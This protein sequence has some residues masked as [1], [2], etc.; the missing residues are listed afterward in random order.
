MCVGTAIE[1]REQRDAFTLVEL[2]V[3]IAVIAILASLLLPA[4]GRAKVQAR[5]VACLNNLKQLGLGT[6]MYA[7]DHEGHYTAPTWFPPE[8]PN[9]PPDADRSASDDDLSFLYA[10][11]PNTKSFN[12]PAASRHTIRNDYWVNMT[13]TEKVLGDLV[14]LAKQ[15]NSF[16]GLSYEVFGL[17][18][19]TS[20]PV[21]R[22]KKT[23]AR[24]QSFTIQNNPTFAGMRPGSSDVFLMVDS[25]TGNG[26]GLVPSRG[27]NSN[28]PD[29]EDNHGNEGSNM[30]FCDGHAEFV[31]RARWLDVWNISQD[32]RRAITSP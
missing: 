8:L 4:L 20:P 3:V 10:H 28:Y 25:D 26:P 16:R 12:C 15:A 7:M 23:E 32:T 5:R 27:N 13:P 6:H 31:K 30:A 18:T 21:P 29:P 14:V 2:L 22:P 11:A 17:F 9:V 1:S 24:L 19:G